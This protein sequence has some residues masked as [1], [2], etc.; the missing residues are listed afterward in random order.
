MNE[1]S[2]ARRLHQNGLVVE[3]E[4]RYR[5]ALENTPQDASLLR[6]LG[7]LLMQSGRQPEALQQFNRI[8]LHHPALAASLVPKA[9]CERDC[10]LLR[11]AFATATDATT[12]TPD[13][14]IGWLLHGSLQVGN[15]AP[16]AAEVSLRQ[17]LQ[18]APRLAEARHFLGECLQLQG[19]YDEAIAEY[20]H[21]LRQN[22]REALN[23]AQCA[24]L[25]GNLTLARQYYEHAVRVLPEQLNAHARLLH[26]LRVVCDF[27]AQS[28]LRARLDKLL[29]QTLATNDHAEPFLLCYQ[30]LDAADYR[31]VLDQYAGQY[32]PPPSSAYTARA[33]RDNS[34]IHIG[35]L[36]ADF[37]NHAVGHLIRDL[38]AAH[39]HQNFKISGFSLSPLANH[40]DTD[41]GFDAFFELNGLPDDQAI[42]L[43]SAQEVDVLLDLGGYTK[44][45]R[46]SLLAAR[47]ARIQL[48][49]LGFISPQ[50]APWLDG[51]IFD[52][53]V[54]PTDAEWPFSDRIVRMSSPLLP[55]FPPAAEVY[56]DRIDFGLPET[57]PLLVSLNNTYKLSAALI[58]AWV[59]ILTACPTATLAIY[60]PPHAREGISTHWNRCDGDISR[61]IFIDNVDRAAHLARMQCC[62]LML[63]AFDYSAGATAID[64]IAT[65][66]P[67]LCLI[68][69]S[70]VARMSASINHYLELPDLIASTASDY[71]AKA[72]NLVNGAG[73][74][75][76]ARQALLASPK[77]LELLNPRRTASEIEDICRNLMGREFHSHES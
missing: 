63:D 42:A 56:A 23:I 34:P 72:I 8:P 32:P 37:N 52:S 33:P 18:L 71:V 20:M 17:C 24:E 49:W 10:G 67:I 15:G 54:Q 1:A 77:R 60:A 51:L 19:R 36:S 68:G 7:V 50:Q 38:A 48:G 28:L 27:P 64:A 30:H 47:P 46:P 4:A 2:Q 16:A 44:G 61:L 21:V 69:D 43:I 13:D 70:P 3:A 62:D 5:I 9:L 41:H 57:G 53:V 76:R 22:P 59:D 73:A 40:I 14:P 39:D 75:D 25:M 31:K 58:S 35:Y 66:L 74:L 11:Q 29:A 45:A 55:G 65:G 26:L 12:L 6:D